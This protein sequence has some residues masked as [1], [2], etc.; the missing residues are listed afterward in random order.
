MK[1]IL[2]LLKASHL[3]P[4]LAVTLISFLLASSLW[5]EGPAF[6][7]AFGIFLGQLLVGF[8]NDLYDYQD[9]LEHNR[10]NKPLVAA[11]ISSRQLINAIKIITPIAIVVNLAGPLGINGGLIY[12][13]GVAFGISYNFYFK[14]TL[15]SPLPYALAFAALVSCIVVATDRTP[16]LWLVLSASCLGV[17]AHFANV[18]KDL[19]ADLKSNII[20][21][22][23]RLGKRVSKLIIT[24]LLLGTTLLLNATNPNLSLLVVGVIGVILTA[25]SPDR[26]IFKALIITVVVDLILLLNTADA[27]IGSIVI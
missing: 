1:L 16:P 20:G 19:N 22:P 2:N 9:D 12:L 15:L 24:L 18:I 25:I 14:F 13:L 10:V 11:T 17:A 4:T 27:K 26:F 8:T 7:I 6:V 21:L 23:Q 5:W 3:A